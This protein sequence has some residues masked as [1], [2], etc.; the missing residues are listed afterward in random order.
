M[1]P[2]FVADTVPAATPIQRDQLQLIA[3]LLNLGFDSSVVLKFRE[4]LLAEA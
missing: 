1:F 4:K 3:W 2:G